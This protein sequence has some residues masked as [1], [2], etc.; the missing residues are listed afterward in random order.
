VQDDLRFSPFSLFRAF[1][2]ESR[3]TTRNGNQRA[4]DCRKKRVCEISNPIDRR[5]PLGASLAGEKDSGSV[6]WG[7]QLA[8]A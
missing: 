4:E 5:I 6:E 8:D 3:N 2:N 7:V 1:S